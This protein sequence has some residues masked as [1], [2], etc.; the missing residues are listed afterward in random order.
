M[1]FE[2]VINKRK[3]IRSYQSTPIPEKVLTYLLQTA[4]LAPS[5]M[6]KQCWHFIIINKP[7]LIQDIAKTSLINRWVKQ[8]PTLIVAC[9]DPHDSGTNNNIS[10][11]TVDVAIAMEHIVLAATNQGLGTC[12]I[13]S[14]DEQK[15]KTILDIPPRIRI[16]AYTPLG[17]P[18]EKQSVTGKSRSFLARSTKRKPLS[19]ISH[20]NSW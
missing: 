11:Y 8:A 6:N 9:A 5:W 12:W 19:K 1:E 3:S 14:F 20:Y 15:L 10:Y 7:S 16:I 17:Y 13:G 4:Q 2:T 18:K